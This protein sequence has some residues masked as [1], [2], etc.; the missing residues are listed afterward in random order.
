MIK[1]NQRIINKGTISCFSPWLMMAIR[2]DGMI[3]P[4]PP[5]AEYAKGCNVKNGG[6]KNIWYGKIFNDFRKKIIE[7]KKHPCCDNCGSM[8]VIANKM[9]LKEI[10]DKG[11]DAAKRKSVICKN[12]KKSCKT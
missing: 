12:K 1:K 5:G 9:V 2:A 7:G 10:M 6:L 3:G 8:E 11:T 4:C